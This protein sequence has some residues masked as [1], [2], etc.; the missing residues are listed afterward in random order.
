M[1][2]KEIYYKLKNEEKI[3]YIYLDGIIIDEYQAYVEVQ[4]D[5]TDKPRKIMG[6]DVDDAKKNAKIFFENLKE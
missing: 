5:L 3:G 2:R 1:K 6:L 4:L